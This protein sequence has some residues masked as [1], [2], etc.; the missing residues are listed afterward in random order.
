[1]GF[2]WELSRY[3]GYFEVTVS[4]QQPFQDATQSGKMLFA[5]DELLRFDP[6]PV[7]GVEGFPD[8]ARRV[9][10]ISFDRYFGIVN[11]GTVERNMGA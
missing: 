2:Q 10:E 9:M 5:R 7:D 8:M 1:M 4:V 6:A 11:Q 3:D